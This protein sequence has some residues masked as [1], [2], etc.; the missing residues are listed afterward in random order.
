MLILSRKV[1]QSIVIGRI[2]FLHVSRVSG[3]QVY[4]AIEAPKTVSVDRKEVW[5][6]KN[7][8]APRG[9]QVRASLRVDGAGADKVTHV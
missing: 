3:G 7:E 1:G 8:A 2:V 4:L 5:L 9:T 6:A